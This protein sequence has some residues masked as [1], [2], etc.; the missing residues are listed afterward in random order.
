M[1]RREL[2]IF[3][4][5]AFGRTAFN[6]YWIQVEKFLNACKRLVELLPILKEVLLGFVPNPHRALSP[7]QSARFVA[8]LH[9]YDHQYQTFFYLEQ[10]YRILFGALLVLKPSFPSSEKQKLTLPENND[11]LEQN[12]RGQSGLFKKC[13]SLIYAI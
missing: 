10:H 3:L 4:A 1:R 2:F 11:E 12:Q 13:L 5:I 9:V 8:S 6:I 7:I